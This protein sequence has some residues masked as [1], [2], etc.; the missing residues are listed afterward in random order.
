MRLMGEFFFLLIFVVGR[1]G[2]VE[3]SWGRGGQVVAAGRQRELGG[4]FEMS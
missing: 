3:L 2:L 4:G 1:D